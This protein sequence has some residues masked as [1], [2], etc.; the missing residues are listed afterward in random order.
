MVVATEALFRY[1][2]RRDRTRFL[3]NIYRVNPSRPV[4]VPISILADIAIRLLRSTQHVQT[5][6]PQGDAV[7]EQLESQLVPELVRTGATLSC[8]LVTRFVTACQKAPI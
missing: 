2:P 7:R 6:Q 5:S 1:V 4:L 3:I 8:I